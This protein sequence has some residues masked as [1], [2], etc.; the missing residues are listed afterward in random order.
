MNGLHP[1]KV[2]RC[3]NCHLFFITFASKQATCRR[4]GMRFGFTSK[5]ESR[6]VEVLE[7]P[8]GATLILGLLNQASEAGPITMD[9]ARH[10]VKTMKKQIQQIG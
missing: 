6:L 5:A 9:Q 2:V 3:P 10:I 8:R 7:N 1:A 4:C